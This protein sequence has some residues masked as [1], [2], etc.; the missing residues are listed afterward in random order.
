MSRHFEEMLSALSAAEVEFLVVGSYSL[1]PH[2]V[3]RATNAFDVWVRP[4]AENARRVMRALVE[5]GAPG[6]R[7]TEEDFR[8][9]GT[10]F[11]IGVPP[12]RIDLV[13]ACEAL[14]FEA[15]WSRR[16]TATAFGRP[17]SCLSLED[18]VRNKRTVGRPKDLADLALLDEAAEARRRSPS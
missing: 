3:V 10:I 15:A 5:F 6:D 16:V 12:F 11:Q 8:T 13:T 9:P 4:T 2:G 14:V 1:A 7:I 17:V 18:I